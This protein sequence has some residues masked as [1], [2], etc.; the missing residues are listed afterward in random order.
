VELAAATFYRSN[1]TLS[2]DLAPSRCIGEVGTTLAH[3]NDLL[4]QKSRLPGA[5]VDKFGGDSKRCGLL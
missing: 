2:K 1:V 3:D 5:Q 4:R